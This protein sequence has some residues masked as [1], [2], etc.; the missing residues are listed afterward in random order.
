MTDPDPFAYPATPHARRH[1]PRGYQDYGDYK[2]WLRDEFAFR[3]VY[4]L[5]REAWYPDRAA[6]FSVDHFVPRSADP[7]RECDYD[8]LVYACT[9]CNSVKQA[10][11]VCLDPALVAY[12]D[13][14]AVGPDS[15]IAALSSEGQDVIDLFHLD[16]EPAVGVRREVFA[17]LTARADHP[18]S[19]AVDAL[20]RAHFGYP[21]DLPDLAR[22]RPSGGNARPDG[23]AASHHARR[24]RGELPAVY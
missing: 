14:L 19:P 23:V 6:S 16:D 7:A 18:G 17:V 8:N 12:A 22:L 24:A 9:R 15:R 13:H 1:G 11:V 20:Y 21:A 3:C 4:C 2:P 10:G 5:E